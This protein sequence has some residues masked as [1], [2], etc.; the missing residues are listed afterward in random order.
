MV[1]CPLFLFF[2]TNTS[3]LNK[4]RLR[5][6]LISLFKKCPPMT[7]N[8]VFCFLSCL[9]L[10]FLIATINPLWELLAKCGFNH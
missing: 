9:C 7:M 8:K 6:D 1:L 2:K 5:L 4:E 3:H 10:L